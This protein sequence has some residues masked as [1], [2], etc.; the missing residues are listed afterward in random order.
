M[1]PLT[2]FLLIAICKISFITGFLVKAYFSPSNSSNIPRIIAENFFPSLWQFTMCSW[3]KPYSFN[4]HE[5]TI[6]SYATSRHSEAI[7]ICLQRSGQEYIVLFQIQGGWSEFKCPL[8]WKQGQW[9]HLCGTWLAP[10]KIRRFYQNGQECKYL[11]TYYDFESKEVPSGGTLAIGQ[12]QE[13]PDS[14][15]QLHRSWHGDIAEVHIWD[16]ILSLEQIRDTGS[17]KGSMR[18][19]NIFAWM[20]TPITVK[21]NVVLS[22]THLCYN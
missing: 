5:L 10:T 13:A 3:L 19:G 15:Y 14:K 9:H 1:S 11:R 12:D 18:E 4:N 6:I 20:K 8:P 7:F 21:D 2:I 17:C 22:A 16:E